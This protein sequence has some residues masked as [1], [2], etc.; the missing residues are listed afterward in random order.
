MWPIF[1]DEFWQ[2]AWRTADR[3]GRVGMRGL[4]ERYV[5]W[6]DGP[7]WPVASRVP[8]TIIPV[9]A[10]YQLEKLLDNGVGGCCCSLRLAMV[11]LCTR[12][13]GMDSNASTIFCR[14]DGAVQ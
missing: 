9:K 10:S 14:F 8:L 12:G 6:R 5:R 13:R 3:V 2:K 7:F 1:L 4:K 11:G